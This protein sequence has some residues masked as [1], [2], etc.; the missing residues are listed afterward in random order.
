M[1]TELIYSLIKR[2]EVKNHLICLSQNDYDLHKLII[3]L[4][5]VQET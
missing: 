3:F 2:T 5:V 1:L 4:Y